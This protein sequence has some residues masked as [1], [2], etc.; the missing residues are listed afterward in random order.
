M[1][2]VVGAV[3]L[4]LLVV[5]CG[6]ASSSSGVQ[7]RPNPTLLGNGVDDGQPTDGEDAVDPGNPNANTP[8]PA[9]TTPGQAAGEMAVTVSTAT[10]LVDLGGTVDITVTLTPKGTFA[11]DAD[12]SVTGLPAGA[13]GTFTPAKVTL[14]AAPATAKLTIKADVTA[15]PTAA[16]A[17]SPL[18]ITAKSGT[19]TATAN[20]SFKLNPALKLTIPLNIDALRSTGTVFLDQWGP[21]FGAN[22][23]PLKT[24]AGN[25]IVVTVYNADSK[26]H[27]VHGNAGFAHGSTTAGQEIQPNAFELVN[28]A[29]RT[30]TFLPG[31][32]VNG[33]P[34]E[35]AAGASAGF[36]FSVVAAP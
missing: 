13:T 33:Y 15:V 5:A 20:A 21:A 17:S 23:T 29:P 28:G 19:V 14:G 12:L 27:I 32:S 26:Q 10:P 25:G 8:P 36:R 1:S 2:L 3:S 16:G 9:P 31:A 11:G 6:D 22:P 30:R 18:V 35:G 34:H 7:R 24:Q 4:S